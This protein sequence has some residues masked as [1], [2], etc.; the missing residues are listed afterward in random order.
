LTE[1]EPVQSD[2]T[3]V[4]E[5]LAEL[6]EDRREAIGAV[7]DVIVANLPEGYEETMLYGMIS[8]VIPLATY[9]QTYN[10]QPLC[11]I[12]LASQKRHMALYLNGVYTDRE[13]D[14]RERYEAS[15]Q[16]LDMGKSCVRSTKLEKLP[17][18]VIA[19]EVGRVTPAQLIAGYEDARASSKRR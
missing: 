15:G 11:Y 3:T 7:R 5:Y 8:Y 1:G 19:D 12:G 2:A 10:D 13:A 16:K 18:D 17:L 4:E 14:F 6:P 9:P